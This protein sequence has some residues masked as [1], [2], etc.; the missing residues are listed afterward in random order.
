MSLSAQIGERPDDIPTILLPEPEERTTTGGDGGGSSSARRK[1]FRFGKPHKDILKTF[2]E[3]RDESDLFVDLIY[4]APSFA[5]MMRHWEGE[6]EEEGSSSRASMI[7]PDLSFDPNFPLGGDRDIMYVHSGGLEGVNSQML[8]YRYDGLVRIEDVQ[9]PGR[10][11][12][13]RK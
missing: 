11:A 1:Y 9:L 5:I 3:L 2:R 8:R 12:K 10:R 13:R 6:D 4:G 7:S